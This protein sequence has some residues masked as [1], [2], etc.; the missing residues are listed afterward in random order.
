MDWDYKEVIQE[1]ICGSDID[2]LP[3]PP[4]ILDYLREKEPM[5]CFRILYEFFYNLKL[6]KA[7]L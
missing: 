1:N 5:L 2:S 7:K 4:L 3:L 6:I